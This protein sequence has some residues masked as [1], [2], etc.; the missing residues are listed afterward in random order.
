MRRTMFLGLG[1]ALSLAGAAAAQ[2]AGPGE[3]RRERAGDERGPRGP[4]MRGRG[5]P[6]GLLLKGITLTEGQR[7]RIAQLRQQQ[8]DQFESRRTALRA[9]ADSLRAARQRGDTVA[10]QRLADQRRAEMTREREQ[11]VAAIRALLTAEQRVQ[12]DRN[13]AELKE[14]VAQRGERGDRGERGF[15]GKRGFRGERGR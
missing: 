13:V 3:A 14:R 6:D 2:Q 4:G 1:L 8:R 12:F 10:A 9:Q 5:G 15:R 11:H 7:A